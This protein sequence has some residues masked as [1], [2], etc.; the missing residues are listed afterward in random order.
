MT[1]P[2]QRHEHGSGYTIRKFARLPGLGLLH[3]QD[4][5]QYIT[6]DDEFAVGAQHTLRTTW[7]DGRM[8]TDPVK[9]RS[10][11]QE[12]GWLDKPE[13]EPAGYRCWSSPG[14]PGRNGVTH[15]THGPDK[16]CPLSSGGQ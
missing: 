9:A 16:P 1:I 7:L 14:G 10:L 8:I 11:W 4:V 12:A 3:G 13:P 15:H 2:D 6:G 5:Y